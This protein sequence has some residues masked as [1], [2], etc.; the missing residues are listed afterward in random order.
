MRDIDVVLAVGGRARRAG[1][2]G[3]DPAGDQLQERGGAG[4][5]PYSS[6]CTPSTWCWPAA[7]ALGALAAPER[8]R[9]ES[10]WRN[11][12]APARRWPA[13][14]VRRRRGVGHCSGRARRAGVGPAGDQLQE[15]DGAG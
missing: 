7:A 4:Q 9:P 12:M 2:A 11:V 8:I 1:G 6:W 13:A 10:S 15:R 14:C 3:E 5:A